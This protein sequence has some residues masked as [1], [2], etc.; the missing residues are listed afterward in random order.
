MGIEC[1]VYQLQ[2]DQLPTALYRVF[3]KEVYQL[4][5]FPLGCITGKERG[6]GVAVGVA[7]GAGDLAGGGTEGVLAVT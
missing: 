6:F 4:M 3:G 7:E 5:T 2:G 1:L